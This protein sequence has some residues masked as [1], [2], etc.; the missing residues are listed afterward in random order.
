MY[1]DKN[2]LFSERAGVTASSTSDAV[3]LYPGYSGGD[4]PFIVVLAADYSGSGSLE[5]QLETSANADF[6]G[7]RR[8]AS[9][10]VSAAELAAG[11]EVLAVSLPRNVERYVRLAYVVTGS[12]SALKISAMLALD[13]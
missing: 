8:V 2:T 1:V 5:V 4:R 10:P 3:D 11:G 13:I 6:S 9:F 12:V 7:S